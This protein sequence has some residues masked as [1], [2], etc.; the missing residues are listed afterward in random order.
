VRPALASLAALA[1]ASGCGASATS[2]ARPGPT[3]TSRAAQAELA[4][5]DT[6]R[7]LQDMSSL[8]KSNELIRQLTEERLARMSRDLGT[9]L[10]AGLAETETARATLQLR[11]EELLREMRLVQGKLEEN[12]AV[13]AQLQVRLD[14]TQVQLGAAMRR[15]EGVEQRVQTTAA[16]EP[17]PD[18]SVTLL[19]GL[20]RRVDGADAQVRAAL[21]RLEGL[22]QQL[23]GS[24]EAR[25]VPPAV[26]APPA[27]P[28]APTAAARPG[29]A[30]GHVAGRRPAGSPPASASQAG[31]S[32]EQLYRDAFND[33]A[34]GEYDSAI[35]GF[36]SYVGSHPKTSLAPSAQYWLAESYYS[37]SKYPEAIQGFSEVLREY[38]NS[39][40]AP[41]AL[42][43]QGE[44][45]LQLNDTKQ[46]AAA[47]CGV[48]SRFPKSREAEMAK[49]HV[50]CG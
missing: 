19:N 36:R 1:L 44:V 4:P 6:A 9:R 27:S 11:L 49:D 14:R 10:D 40:K 39:D 16:G 38:P 8:A 30:S 24:L 17:K 22:E 35:A 46:A 26:D 48:I 41:S 18:E 47:L 2:A 34:R 33:Y 28:A 5:E 45:Y 37:Q 15:L 13:L 43:R 42:F 21:K 31:S 50:K 12:A 7:L 20:H 23:R 29:G 3:A 25:A 32:P